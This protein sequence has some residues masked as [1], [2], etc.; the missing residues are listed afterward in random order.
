MIMDGLKARNAEEKVV[1]KDIAEIVWEAM[2]AQ[3]APKEE[4]KAEA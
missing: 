2:E 4:P 3:A 1:A